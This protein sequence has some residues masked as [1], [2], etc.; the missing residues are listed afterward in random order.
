M[1][2]KATTSYTE[3]NCVIIQSWDQKL[4][5]LEKQMLKKSADKNFHRTL[6]IWCWKSSENIWPLRQP[7][8]FQVKAHTIG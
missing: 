4:Q 3:G 1:F 7:L 5:F 2:H 8:P 6:H